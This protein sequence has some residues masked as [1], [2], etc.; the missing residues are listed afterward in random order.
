MLT[1]LAECVGYYQK[2]LLVDFASLK[3]FALETGG[4]RHPA[5][6]F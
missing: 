6:V 1:P 2:T 5:A 4:R 3:L